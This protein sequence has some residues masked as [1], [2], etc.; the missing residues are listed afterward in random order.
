MWPKVL[1]GEYNG[2]SIE[3]EGKGYGS[4]DNHKEVVEVEDKYA[5]SIHEMERRALFVVLE[6]QDSLDDVKDAHGDYYDDI[7]IEKA[8]NKFNRHCRKAGL[9]HQYEIDNELAVI[10]Q[11]FINPAEFTID[12]GIVVKKGAW[13]QWWHFPEPDEPERDVLWPKVLSGE[14][15]GVSIECEG[16]GYE[17]N[18]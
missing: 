1:S 3:C 13:L 15:N 17:I 6:P 2:V 14:Y 10:E 5:K 12:D 18:D 11:S 16:K 7:T 9:L 4:N 8:C